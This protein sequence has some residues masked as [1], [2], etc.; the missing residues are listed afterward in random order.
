MQRSL[1]WIE[2][3]D[4]LNRI[5]DAARADMRALVRSRSAHAPASIGLYKRQLSALTNE[6]RWLDRDVLPEKPGT[7][8]PDRT[9]DLQRGL[10]TALLHLG[11]MAGSW[12]GLPAA[13]RDRLLGAIDAA[14]RECAYE[15]AQ[16]LGPNKRRA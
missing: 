6:L 12:A 15:A 16:L 9:H 8:K 4:R 3:F 11:S 5:L 2:W 7:V 1:S 14:L 10:D 13:A